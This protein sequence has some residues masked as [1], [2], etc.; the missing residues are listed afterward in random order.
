MIPALH[1]EWTKVRTSPGTFWLLLA[2]IALT[3]GLGVAADASTS[4]ASAGCNQDPAKIGL[5]GVYLGQVL[6]AVSAVTIVSAEYGTG[7]M[8]VTLAA[9]PK[10]IAVLTAKATMAIGWAFA[11]GLAGIVGSMAI[12]Q[13]MLPGKGFTAAHGYST[14]FFSDA[15]MLRAVFGSVLYFGLIALLSLGIAAAVRDSAAGVGIVLGLLFLFPILTAAVDN[16]QWHRHLEQLTPMNAG[17]SIQATLNLQSLPI[18]P[19]A[20]LGVLAAWAAAALLLGGLV[21][22]LRDA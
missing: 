8:R 18:A 2:A 13:L 3:I 12:A 10:R 21:L 17:L 15:E 5:T 1:A 22:Q 4:C 14:S 7:M 9:M 16:D 6:V 19:W 11:A 20:G